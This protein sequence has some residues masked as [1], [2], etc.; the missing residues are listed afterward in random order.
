MI[1]T[2]D[3]NPRPSEPVDADAA[4]AGEVRAIWGG[5][6]GRNPHFVGRRTLLDQLRAT[7]VDTSKASVL[8]QTLQGLGGVGK[9]MVAVEYVY[10]YADE[11]DWIWWISAEEPAEIRASLAE[12]GKQLN[13]PPSVD[14]SQTVSAVL[15]K[16]GSAA[17]RWLLVYDNADL[18]SDL[19]DLTPTAGGHVLITSRNQ[20][21]GEEG[22]AIEVDLFDRPESIQLLQIRTPMI[23]EGEAYLLANK[24]GDLPLA[25][26][27]AAI[28]RASTGMPVTEYLELFDEHASELMSE[29]LPP[30]YPFPAAVTFGMAFD[31]LKNESV[32][33][34]QLLELFTCL[35]SEPVPLSLL[36]SGRGSA[37]ISPVLRSALDGSIE[38]SRAIRSLRRYGLA[39]VDANDRQIWVHRLVQAILREKLEPEQLAEARANVH[40]ILAQAAKLSEPDDHS[41][42]SRHMEIRPHVIPSDLIRS[43]N[44][45]AP[46]VV[47]DQIRFLYASG[48]Y[49]GSR[50]LGERALV[51][52]SGFPD[53]HEHT[54]LA[55]RHLA[56]TL[57]ALGEYERAYELDQRVLDRLIAAPAY[58]ERHEHT[59]RTKNSFGADLRIRG[60]FQEALVNDQEN[61]ELHLSVFTYEDD[62]NVLRTKGNLAVDYRLTGDFRTAQELDQQIVISRQ[63]AGEKTPLLAS[64]ISNL[65]RD[66]YDLGDYQKALDLQLEY[67]ALQREQL[68][69][70][71]LH[72]L[73]A[74]RTVAMARRKLGQYAEALT[75][76]RDLDRD[77]RA[78]LGH[79]HEH[80]LLATMTHVNSLRVVG[81]LAE[82]R[83]LGEETIVHYRS[84]FGEEH[85]FTLAALTNLAILYR[86]SAEVEPKDA[87]EESQKLAR[88]LDEFA[89]ASLSQVLGAEH[90]YALCA[91]NNLAN[92]LWL[93]GEEDASRKLS[94]RT[95]LMSVEKRG[96]LTPYTL[97]CA[98]NYALALREVEAP[99]AEP[100]LAATLANLAQVRGAKHPATLDAGRG[101]RAECDIEPPPT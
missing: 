58:G 21:W 97:A 68:G 77:H 7:L 45:D 52:W 79:D 2:T 56:N 6:P 40:E 67:Q 13:L 63:L 71:H 46:Q 50:S 20:A 87:R 42:W 101:K 36:R 90:P 18:P 85:P 19:T 12:L 74:A 80:T 57:R 66:Y 92:D 34:A 4:G 53:D 84:S 62:P 95:Y 24:L 49:E 32:A 30:N 1:T 47:L 89:L 51:A 14:L 31:R 43:D 65:A 83:R 69:P 48:D 3:Q 11:Y 28:W 64:S 55:T 10:R 88:E 61:L 29:G 54:L 35:G 25:L 98:V 27:Q 60:N 75:L 38:L 26:E 15:S 70:F 44:P 22:N 76:A 96:E 86:T 82:A 94:E 93:D 81:E 17:Q 37:G 33:A 41:T 99:E 78:R 100:L 16:L 91:A 5:V 72:V 39:K 9:T 59:L 23:S 73:L 8:P